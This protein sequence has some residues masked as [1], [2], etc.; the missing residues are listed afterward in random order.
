MNGILKQN[1]SKVGEV[2]NIRF[3]AG[4]QNK[5]NVSSLDGP[6]EIDGLREPD[7]V[8]FDATV[9]LDSTQYTLEVPAENRTV[10]II[11]HRMHNLH[12]RGLVQ[13]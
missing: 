11:V 2:E 4:R 6:G 3:I 10:R 13:S 12:C 1:E 9:P 8:E 5:I 7:E